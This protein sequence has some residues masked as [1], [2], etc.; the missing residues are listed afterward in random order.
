MNLSPTQLRV[1]RRA[2]GREA[3]NICPTPGLHAGAQEMVMRAMERRGLLKY[4]HRQEAQEAGWC[5]E[6]VPI[7]SG[8]GRLLAAN[9][10]IGAT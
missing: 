5:H 3:G 10:A 2:A 4:P 8:C 1:L 9:A 7:I 6:G